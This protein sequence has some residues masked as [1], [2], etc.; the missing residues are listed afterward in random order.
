MGELWARKFIIFI[1]VD[2]EHSSHCNNEGPKQVMC[3]KG[4]PRIRFPFKLKHEQAQ[5][6]GYPGFELS[7]DNNG[8]TVMEFPH[9]VQLHVDRIDYVSQQIFLSDPH[10]CVPGKMLLNLNL[11][12]TPF[13]YSNPAPILIEYSLFNCSD[14]ASKY[15][16]NFDDQII[17][18]LG[19][20]GHQVPF[21][22]SFWWQL[23]PLVPTSFTAEA[24]YIK[25]IRK[26]LRN[27]WKITELV[28][29]KYT[30]FIKTKCNATTYPYPCL[31][32]LLP[33]AASVRG[34]ATKMCMA[35][36]KVA[37][38]VARNATLTVN[39]MKKKKGISTAKGNILRDCID[40]LK[41]VVYNREQLGE[42]ARRRRK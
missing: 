20:P 42:D 33:Y 31:K 21:Q 3:R 2:F 25:R 1:R 39:D 5:H 15:P 17:P 36:L 9:A 32:T 14:D 13:Q 23:S 29:A 27:F 7:C 41:D 28:P 34:N 38:Q 10:A 30:H 24:K 8:N 35:T 16:E 40:D 4:G 37:V 22:D 12:E 18:C 6:C 19:V 26:E 11:S